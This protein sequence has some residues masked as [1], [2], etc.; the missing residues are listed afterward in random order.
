MQE[1]RKGEVENLLSLIRL[2]GTEAD[3]PLNPAA[4]DV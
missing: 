4:I 1:D 2:H 3:V